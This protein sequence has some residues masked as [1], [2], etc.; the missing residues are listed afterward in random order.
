[1]TLTEKGIELIN[2]GSDQ[3]GTDDFAD[4]ADI[5]AGFRRIDSLLGVTLCTSLSKPSEPVKGQIIFE[6]DLGLLSVYNATTNQWVVLS[7]PTGNVPV[8]TIL[9][10][11][12]ATPPTS[13]MF[14]EGASLLKSEYPPLFA[15]IGTQYGSA[16]ATRFNAPNL[17]GRTVV[18]MDAAQA[19]FTTL[20][21][22]G[23][24]KTHTLT[25]PEMPSHTHLPQMDITSYPGGNGG[26]IHFGDSAPSHPNYTGLIGS[27]GGN[28]PHNNLQ[29]Y[30]AMRF[31]IKF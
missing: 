13:Y 30:A 25:I 8:G 18:G 1:M 14:A 29:P 24:S 7:N 19:E 20:G 15:V 11:A 21:Q 12:G 16:D 22:T 31:I 9:T 23:G 27:T 10:Y 28:L 5:N 6:T 4:V 17:K 26:A 2:G 3:P